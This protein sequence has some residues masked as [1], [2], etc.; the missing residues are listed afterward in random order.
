MSPSQE[1]APKYEALAKA[2]AGDKDVVIAKVDATEERELADKYDISGFPTIKFFPANSADPEPYEQARDL[3]SMVKFI[4]EKAGTM[5]N[6]DGSLMPE[7]GRVPALEDLISAA[8]AFDAKLVETLKAA[9]SSLSGTEA[10]YG[11]QYVAT[12]EKIVAKG[13]EYVAKEIKRLA[14]MIAS[15]SVVP[16]MKTN[17]Q[18]RQNVLQAFVKA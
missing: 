1:L 13:E 2:F 4:N 7:A 18:L 16:E 9:V 12:A 10:K 5:R 17:F 14:G 3:E 6:P 15:P 8:E 11:S